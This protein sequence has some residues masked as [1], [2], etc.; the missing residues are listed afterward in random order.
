[1]SIKSKVFAAAATLT[2]VGGVGAAGALTATQRG[3]PVVRSQLH[4]H[5]QPEFGTPRPTRTSSWT[6]SAAGREGRP[7]DHPVP[8]QQHRPG[9][10][11]HHLLPGH[12]R[13]LLRR[14]AWCPSALNSSTTA[15][16]LPAFEFEYSPY[17]V[18]SGLCMG[19]GAPPPS[20]TP[21]SPSSRAACPPR[22]SGSSTPP[23]SIT[24][25][26]SST[27]RPADQRLGHQ[28][29]APVRADLPAQ[30]L[31]DRQ[32]AP[33]A[34]VPSNLHRLLA[35]SVRSWHIRQPAVGR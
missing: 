23:D 6:C 17:G 15:R 2:L 27:L 3:H 18:N 20:M 35:R 4:R 34:Q 12:G 7:A 33:A 28:L 25:P 26:R 5:L 22:P 9:G 13:R 10:R 24:A 16:R 29:L 31:P 1:M 14:R 21:G 11:L 32:A 30:R 19:V 8:H